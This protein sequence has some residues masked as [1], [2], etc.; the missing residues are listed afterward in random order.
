M[1]VNRYEKLF[2]F[3]FEFRMFFYN[4]FFNLYGFFLKLTDCTDLKKNVGMC[5]LF[6]FFCWKF[7][8]FCLDFSQ[9]V[10]AMNEFS[11]GYFFE[12]EK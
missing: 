3:S 11:H 6:W 2:F 8:N 1:N 4:I 7:T 10:L 12:E 9:K 5:G